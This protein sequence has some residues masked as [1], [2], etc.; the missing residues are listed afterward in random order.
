MT[1]LHVEQ[2]DIV[3]RYLM[4]QLPPELRAEFEEHYIACPDCVEDLE[5]SERWL[6]AARK[7]LGADG[8]HTGRPERRFS[9]P[10]LTW[11][12]VAAGSALA[13]YLWVGRHHI[14]QQPA[15]KQEIARNS[16][17]ASIPTVELQTYRN[18][19][20]EQAPIAVSAARAF[21]L[22]LDLRGLESYKKYLVQIVGETGEMV[23]SSQQ[24]AATGYWL[25][26]TVENAPLKAGGY[27]VRVFGVRA[28]A[29]PELLREYA[30]AV[31][32]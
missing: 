27:W 8:G 1:H 20:G 31:A 12:F 25:E 29:E 16:A 21:R 30:L 24:A 2:Q 6:R 7:Q 32:P 19:R 17:A 3:E 13:L 26:T 10:A 14:A 9:I 11:G 4:N 15:A 22:R 18:G 23:W 5:W 28:G